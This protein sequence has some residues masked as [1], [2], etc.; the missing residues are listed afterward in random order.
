MCHS[1]YTASLSGSRETER[2]VSTYGFALKS[3]KSCHDIFVRIFHLQK[4]IFN[5]RGFGID[6][7]I[8]EGEFS[9]YLLCHQERHPHPNFV[10][11]NTTVS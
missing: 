8:L 4:E 10:M 6:D 11:G 7:G 9:C 2:E 1:A 3:I 5:G